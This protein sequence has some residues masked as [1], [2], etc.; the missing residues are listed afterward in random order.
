MKYSKYYN[1]WH[2]WIVPFHFFYSFSLSS[3]MIFPSSLFCF[4]LLSFSEISASS[5]F[6]VTSSSFFLLLSFPESSPLPFFF[7]FG[8]SL[9]LCFFLRLDRCHW[10]QP[11]PWSLASLMRST[12]GDACKFGRFFF[13]CFLCGF[14]VIVAGGGVG[15]YKWSWF[16]SSFFFFLRVLCWFWGFFFF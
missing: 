12:S 9:S 16:I 4:F 8:H 11:L 7:F 3:F 1:I 14:H 5:L 6:F 10:D 13:F 15:S 2:T